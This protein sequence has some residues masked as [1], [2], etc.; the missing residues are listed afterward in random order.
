MNSRHLYVVWNADHK[1]GKYK[2][3]LW[4]RKEPDEG[5]R[6]RSRRSSRNKR[7]N[8]KFSYYTPMILRR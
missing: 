7:L 5:A 6:R 1:G 8:K 2:R 3:V 4:G